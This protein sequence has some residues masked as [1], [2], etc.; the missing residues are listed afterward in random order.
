MKI[1]QCKQMVKY[2]EPVCKQGNDTMFKFSDQGLFVYAMNLA[3]TCQASATV[4]MTCFEGVSQSIEFVLPQMSFNLLLKHMKKCDEIEIQIGD[5]VILKQDKTRL[6]LPIVTN[7][8]NP[9]KSP[10][11]PTT[12]SFNITD[13]ELKSVIDE[14][15]DTDSDLI[16]FFGEKGV[17]SV[18]NQ[19]DSLV[20][21]E[22]EI[23]GCDGKVDNKC[24]LALLEHMTP[25][26]PLITLV[27]GENVPITLQTETETMSFVGV[28]APRVGE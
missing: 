16:W 23:G 4:N 6:S 1:K 27:L 11:W 10:N 20:Q 14:V 25:K 9:Y 28:I 21:Y 15:K 12:S 26:E 13:K 22:K 24:T 2:L 7:K 18:K 5:T 17:L 8:V 3:N 19:I